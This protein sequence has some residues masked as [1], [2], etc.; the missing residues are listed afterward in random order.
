MNKQLALKLIIDEKEGKN[1]SKSK[2]NVCLLKDDRFK[3]L[4][5]NPAFQVDTNAEEYK[6][7][8][9]FIIIIIKTKFN[10]K[11]IFQYKIKLQYS[12]LI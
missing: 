6:Q 2:N 4:F 12:L 1:Y 3:A 11:I 9:V 5:E 7:F 10:R 8:N